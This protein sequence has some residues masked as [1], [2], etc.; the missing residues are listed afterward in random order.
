MRE[1]AADY[2]RRTRKGMWDDSRA[3]LSALSLDDRE[4]VVDVGCGTGELS[5]ILAEACPG[6]VVGCDADVRL[7][8]RAAAYV[9][10]VA[11][12]ARQLPF[13]DG[14]ADL[15]VCQALLINLLDPAAVV[16]EFARVSTDLVAAIEPNNGAVTVDSSV[17]AES[18]L[19]ERARRAYLE[20][21]DTDVTLGRGVRELFEAAG[22]DVVATA[23]YDN[24]RSV[25]A[26]Y[27]R[28]QLIDARRKASGADLADRRAIMLDGGLTPEAFDQLRTDWREMGRTVVEQMADSTYT[29]TETVPFHVTVGRVSE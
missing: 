7:L 20:G 21:V 23:R 14:T 3:A 24:D 28:D 29:R 8:E 2:L 6:E 13:A 4:R 26:P 18:Q 11:G 1:F 16:E 19:A 9:P 12:D 25:E 22:I 5:R 17:D 15:V 27:D 10:V